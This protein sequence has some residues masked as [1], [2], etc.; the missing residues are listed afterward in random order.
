MEGDKVKTVTACARR[1]ALANQV[2]GEDSFAPQMRRRRLPILGT[3]RNGFGRQD[4][5]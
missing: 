4:L 3:K 2:E 1:R 5:A